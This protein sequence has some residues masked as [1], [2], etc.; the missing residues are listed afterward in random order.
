MTSCLHASALEH[1][2]CL[3]PVSLPLGGGSVG[4]TSS[5]S[6]RGT[7]CAEGN[8]FPR[9][10]CARRGRSQAFTL[11]LV[12]ACRGRASGSVRTPQQAPQALLRGPRTAPHRRPCREP[13][14]SS[15]STSSPSSRP[16]SLGMTRGIGDKPCGRPSLR[17]QLCTCGCVY[18]C[19]FIPFPPLLG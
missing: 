15:P 16:E 1:Q 3:C 10:H 13:R 8:E 17:G 18:L 5:S 9:S 14:R 12:L 4:A 7:F 19:V 2:L 6:P 11:F